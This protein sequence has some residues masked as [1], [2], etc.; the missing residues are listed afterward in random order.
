SSASVGREAIARGEKGFGLTHE[1]VVELI[2]RAMTGVRI[3]HKHGVRQVLREPI[4]VGDWDH[5]VEDTIDHQHRLLDAPQLA[6]ALASNLL[7]LAE[8]CDLRCRDLRP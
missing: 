4:R 3:G 5:L 7:P 2:Y 8:R 6:E 1:G